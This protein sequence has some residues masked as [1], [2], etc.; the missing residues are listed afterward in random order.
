M[1]VKSISGGAVRS[2][3]CCG[4]SGS[5]GAATGTGTGAGTNI[6][7][8][9]AGAANVDVTGGATAAMGG[10][11]VAPVVGRLPASVST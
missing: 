6:L 9:L 1:L 3:G 7:K 10:I 5:G 11:A 4:C 2:T 8:P